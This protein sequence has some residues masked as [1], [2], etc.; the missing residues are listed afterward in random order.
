ML[1]S[2]CCISAHDDMNFTVVV[3]DLNND[4]TVTVADL[5]NAENNAVSGLSELLA[6]H[7]QGEEQRVQYHM[8]SQLK[9]NVV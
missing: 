4:V 6:D 7:A 3:S 9:D 8:T 5:N 1:A 2:A